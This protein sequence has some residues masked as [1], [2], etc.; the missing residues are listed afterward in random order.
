MVR[1]EYYLWSQ[2]VKGLNKILFLKRYLIKVREN[3]ASYRFYFG[4]IYSDA[5]FDGAWSAIRG[6]YGPWD[7]NI[8]M[9]FILKKILSWH[10]YLFGNMLRGDILNIFAEITK[11]VKKRFTRMS[12]HI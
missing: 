12:K 8:K 1:N 4:E 11:R 5:C 6:A 3:S 2:H 9:P 10:P 7:E